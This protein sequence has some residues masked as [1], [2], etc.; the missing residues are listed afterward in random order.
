MDSFNY[1]RE[2]SQL[3][4]IYQIFDDINDFLGLKQ[5]G[6]KQKDFL[7]KRLNSIIAYLSQDPMHG[8]LI[9]E[10]LDCEVESSEQKEIIEQLNII[11][12][13]ED[14]L[15][16]LKEYCQ[17]LLTQFQSSSLTQAKEIILGE[18][19]KTIKKGNLHHENASL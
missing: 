2:W 10:Y 1:A 18:M 7:E 16:R 3:G 8:P 6:Q 14:I 5:Q 4:V 15:S 17:E 12:L 9:Q 11:I 13:Q 19:Q